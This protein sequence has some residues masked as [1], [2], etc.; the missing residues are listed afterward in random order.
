M[1][2]FW[3]KIKRFLFVLWVSNLVYTVSL[4][5]INPPVTPNIIISI[6]K[7]L[8]TEFGFHHDNIAYDEMGENIKWAVV[9][10]E[11]QTFGDHY[12][13]DFKQ[14]K[15][16]VSEK[17]KKTR[18]AS[19]LTQQ[20]AKNL[21]YINKRS[22]IRK[23]AEMYSTVLLEIFVPKK[24]ILQHY[25]NIAE[26]GPNVYGVQAAAQFYFQKDAKDLSSAEAN[27]LAS[28]LP[29]PIKRGKSKIIR[30]KKTDWIAEQ[31]PYLKK[32]ENL[33]KIIRDE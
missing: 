24:K 18:G 4:R 17:S 20:T 23:A 25:L 22:W 30:S 8:S 6:I 11:D 3:K 27:F 28:I 9:A 13:F 19:T 33:I 29:S 21:F 2:R 10:S 32:D 12:G 31:I 7:N 5:W 14:I 1:R 16:A 15:N 26:L